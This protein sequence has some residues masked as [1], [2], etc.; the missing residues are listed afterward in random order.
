MSVIGTRVP[1]H[2]S[3]F[4]RWLHGFTGY[5]KYGALTLMFIPVVLY[6][7]IFKYIVRGYGAE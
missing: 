1:K 6:F 2:R 3:A 7:F 4:G 5:K